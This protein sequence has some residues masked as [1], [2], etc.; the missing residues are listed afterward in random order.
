LRRRKKE[1]G[2]LPRRPLGGQRQFMIVSGQRDK[3]LTGEE[4]TTPTGKDVAFIASPGRGKGKGQFF[5]M[6]GGVSR[7]ET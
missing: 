5:D 7:R 4:D 2:R 1:G 3:L 6:G